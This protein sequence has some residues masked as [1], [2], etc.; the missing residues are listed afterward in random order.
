MLHWSQDASTGWTRNSWGCSMAKRACLSLVSGLGR[1]RRSAGAP[2]AGIYHRT[3]A[4]CTTEGTRLARSPQVDATGTRSSHW[5]GDDGVNPK[6]RQPRDAGSVTASEFSFLALGLILGVLS[7]RPRRDPPCSTTHAARGPPHRRARRDPPAI[8]HPGRRRVRCTAPQPPAAGP[9]SA[10]GARH[11]SRL[12]SPTVERPFAIRQRRASRQASTGWTR[13]SWGCSITKRGVPFPVGRTRAR[14][15]DRPTRRRPEFTIHPPE[16]ARPEGRDEAAAALAEVDGSQTRTTL[17]R[18]WSREPKGAPAS[19][20]GRRDSERVQLPG[21][22][23]RPRPRH[24]CSP[25]RV[26]PCSTARAA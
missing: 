19:G 22:R 1:V 9:P 16:R 11:P 24:R 10:P 6:E 12:A 7:G 5:P 4:P 15:E 17:A 26:H 2:T 3:P 23:P 18:R 14:T 8:V 20:C 25:R 13:N 21:A